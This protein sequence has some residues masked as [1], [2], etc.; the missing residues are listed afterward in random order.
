MSNQALD[1]LIECELLKTNGDVV[2]VLSLPDEELSRR[3]SFYMN[4]RRSGILHEIGAHPSDAMLNA[5]FST[6][7]SKFSTEKV[8]SSLLVYNKIVLD[9]PLVSSRSAISIEK[10]LEGLKFF[11]W[12][13]PLIRSDFV[14]VYPISYYNKPSESIP[15]LSSEDSFRSSISP[16]IHD[17]VHSNAILRSAIPGDEGCMLVLSEDAFINRRT[18]LNVGFKGDTLYSG[19]GLFKFKTIEDVKIVDGR[20]TY[21]EV[22]DSNG[23]L[24]E[25]KFQHWAYQAINQAVIARLKAV[26]NEAALAHELGHTYITESAFESTL[27]SLS[28]TQSVET[29]SPCVRFLNVNENFLNIESPQQILKLREKYPIAFERFN[30]SLLSVSEELEGVGPEDF[31]RKSNLLF[32]KEIMPQVEE[33]R[34]A[35]GQVSS[36][37]VGGTLTNMCAV[38]LAVTTGSAAPLIPSLL[39]TVSQGVAGV[40]PAIRNVQAM[41]K[42]P[43]YIWHRIVK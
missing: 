1:L 3:F 40:M 21:R 31:D 29:I 13:H 19:V 9:D 25:E 10:L 5:Q 24:S 34:G 8:L 23:V 20:M 33:V 30:G 2:D 42:K 37:V 12:L 28:N 6:W 43:Q 32:H 14:S 22:W 15:L 18:A 27:L 36:G 17:Y 11:S 38:A 35:I 26:C 16:V 41:K 7:S 4:A 39:L